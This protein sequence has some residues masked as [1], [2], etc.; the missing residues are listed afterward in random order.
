MI[1][2]SHGYL[3][4]TSDGIA[5]GVDYLHAVWTLLSPCQSIQPNKDLGP[6]VLILQVDKSAGLANGL[7]ISGFNSSDTLGCKLIRMRRYRSD[8][9]RWD[10][11]VQRTGSRER[12]LGRPHRHITLLA[13]RRSSCDYIAQDVNNRGLP[14]G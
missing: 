2:E 4:S 7:H 14:G 6:Q 12:Q 11:T 3:N 8:N 1:R 13:R 5:N 9:L 10:A